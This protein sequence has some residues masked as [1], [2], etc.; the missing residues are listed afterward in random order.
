MISFLQEIISLYAE[1]KISMYAVNA[2]KKELQNNNI[3]KLEYIH[4][5][6]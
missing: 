6:M 1:S 5:A 2:L 4:K 3:L